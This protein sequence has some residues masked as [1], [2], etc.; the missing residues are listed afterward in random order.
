MS[1]VKRRPRQHHASLW[2]ATDSARRDG[3][4]HASLRG[5]IVDALFAADPAPTAAAYLGLLWSGPHPGPLCTLSQEKTS[6]WKSGEKA[7]QILFPNVELPGIAADRQIPPDETGRD[8]NWCFQSALITSRYPS[9]GLQ[10]ALGALI[11]A[12]IITRATMHGKA[13]V[14]VGAA[15]S[16]TD[17]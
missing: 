11:P 2:V 9:T 1:A 15:T 8:I 4:V 14:S 5:A 6:T 17:I 10:S 3:G 12:N 13:A 7:F 16:V